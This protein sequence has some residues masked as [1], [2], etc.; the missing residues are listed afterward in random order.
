MWKKPRYV[1]PEDM[2]Y[3]DRCML[4]WQGML[5]SDHNERM[6]S[7]RIQETCLK[8]EKYHTEAEYEDWDGLILKSKQTKSPITIL[9]S[10]PNEPQ[11]TVVGVILFSRGPKLRIWTESG[12]IMIERHEVDGIAEHSI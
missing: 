6:R 8:E 10:R 11:F 3:P 4:K 9:V 12:E 7:E 1:K 5:L 2:I